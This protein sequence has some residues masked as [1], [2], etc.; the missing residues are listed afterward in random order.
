MELIKLLPNDP[1]ASSKGGYASFSI[2]NNMIDFFRLSTKDFN[3]A[4]DKSK[5][6]NPI[7]LGFQLDF[8]IKQLIDSYLRKYH[9]KTSLFYKSQR[10]VFSDKV[11]PDE[12]LA[13]SFGYEDNNV[14]D[15]ITRR[16]NTIVKKYG[17]PSCDTI[18]GNGCVVKQG[19]YIEYA[20][21]LPEKNLD[22]VSGYCHKLN[23]EDVALTM[24]GLGT[25]NLDV[26]AFAVSLS[27]GTLANIIEEQES[28]MIN[29]ESYS[30]FLN[31]ENN[32]IYRNHMIEVFKGSEKLSIGDSVNIALTKFKRHEKAGIPMYKI[33]MRGYN[34]QEKPIFSFNT[35]LICEKNN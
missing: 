23:L 28:E 35:T 8:V 29:D 2:N 24:L 3:P 6:D 22:F 12:L 14:D 30:E 34:E 1:Y 7:A 4:H 10:T 11:F 9:A 32:F 19:S 33:E 17:L 27:S 15:T 5:V 18:N 31:P 20:E 21:V 25:V 13:L 16:F 26:L